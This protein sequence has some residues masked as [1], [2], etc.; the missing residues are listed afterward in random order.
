MSFLSRFA[1]LVAALL[2]SG[3]AAHAEGQL[4]AK[5]QA[6]D[7]V[8]ARI[9]ALD[10]PIDSVVT[11]G[12]LEVTVRSCY[13]APPEE[14]PENAVFLEIRELRRNEEPRVV[15]TGWMFSS[16]PGL[17]TLEHPVYDIWVVDCVTLPPPGTTVPNSSSSK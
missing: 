1:L 14:P 13:K 17:S 9:S 8:T 5:L 11:F 4:T 6:L 16:T 3:G 12:T 7:K 15:F 2:V 10:A